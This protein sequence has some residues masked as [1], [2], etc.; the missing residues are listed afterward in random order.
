VTPTQLR[1]FVAVVRLGSVKAA[2]AELEVTEAAVSGHVAQLRRELDD[3]LFV[4]ASSGLAFTPG[5]LRLAS[6]ATEMLGLADL[7]VREVSQAGQGQRMLRLAVTSL[8][9]EYAA[10]GLIELFAGRAAD[11]EV[12]L[13]AVPVSQFTG[14]LASRA[15]DV[16]IG[17]RPRGGVEDLTATPF[18][19]YQVVLVTGAGHPLAGV[20]ARPEA[21]REQTWLLGPTAAENQGAMR[22]L[23]G[24]FRVPEANQRIFQSHAAAL[25]EATRGHGVAPAVAFVVADDVA[26][27][28]LA[29]LDVR[30][31]QADGTWTALSLPPHSRAGA[32]SELL[33]FITSPRATQAMLH[34]SGADVRRFKPSVHVTLWS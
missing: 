32:A 5:G 27:G 30:G 10:P 20:R 34:G 24:S 14:L 7:T 15:A 17:P 19:K 16:A 4:R 1:A 12:E 33:R 31:G 11:L 22:R 13:S 23:L 28:R 3:R 29:R 9:A 21:L 18:L 25:E 6:R 2:A 8:F 26:K